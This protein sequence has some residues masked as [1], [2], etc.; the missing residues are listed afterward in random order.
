[1]I[2]TP[3]RWV[4]VTV[5]IVG[6]SA[7]STSLMAATSMYGIPEPPTPAPLPTAWLAVQDD[8][9]G[10]AVI[11]TDDYR[12][13]GVH[14]GLAL[15]RVVIAVD[16]SALTNRGTN[17]LP[18]GRTDE[19]TYTIGIALIDD[20]SIKNVLS[21]LLI[22]GVGGRT[23]GDYG[24][25]RMQNRIH[26][27]FGFQPLHLQYD[28][29]HGT[30]G[31]GYAYGRSLWLPWRDCPH[32]FPETIGIQVEAAMLATTT[33]EQNETIGIDLVALGAQ[34]VG[35]FG[36][37]YQ[38]NTGTLPTQTA[39]IVAHHE[40][41]WWF[42][43]G[44]GR[45]P[46]LFVS[47][48]YDPS[49]R[50]I[51]GTVGVTIDHAADVADASKL[52][53]SE[54]FEFFPQGGSIGAQVRWQPVRLN[55]QGL[56]RHELLVDY[57]FGSVPHY[58]WY[59]N[60]VDA[61][62]LLIGYEPELAHAVPGMGWLMTEEYIYAAGGVRVERVRVLATPSRYPQATATSPVGQGGGGVRI[63]LNQDDDPRLFINQIRLGLGVDAWV[64]V[65]RHHVESSTASGRFQKPGTA[66]VITIGFNV[67][68]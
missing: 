49:T 12:T 63:G 24:G 55:D 13:G 60:R 37:Q 38:R 11:N 53:A 28:Q 6:L 48:A 62:Q 46:G 47:A 8:L 52:P 68:W 29:D 21:G 43:A 23:T 2:F 18:A 59:N 16:D 20:E 5:A 44:L 41:T 25:Q 9:F 64:P 42:V 33:H 35:W 32:P 27:E 65:V 36:V 1:M 40:N 57:R 66:P 26:N 39:A 30:S 58:S 54:T 14:A 34:G 51:D 45:Q 67:I 3:G 15:E 17:G 61:D 31:V 50:A 56:L 22:I 10:D 19:I 7:S 4:S